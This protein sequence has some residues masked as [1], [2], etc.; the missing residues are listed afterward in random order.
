MAPERRAG[1]ALQ[2]LSFSTTD[3]T[4]HADAIRF[5]GPYEWQAPSVWSVVESFWR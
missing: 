2:A 3:H 5:E 1:G 4:D